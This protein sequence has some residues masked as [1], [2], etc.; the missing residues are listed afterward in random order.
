MGSSLY[1][2]D[3]GSLWGH[4]SIG[5]IIS[6]WGHLSISGTGGHCLINNLMKLRLNLVFL[7]E[8]DGF[9]TVV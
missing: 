2:W 6:V 4:L 3:W 7:S 8:L 5:G 1:W 9:I